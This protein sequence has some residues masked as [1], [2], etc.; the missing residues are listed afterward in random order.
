MLEALRKSTSG[1]IAKVFIG[2]LV[3]SFAV[4]GIED[5]FRTYRQ[6]EVAK[7]GDMVVSAQQFERAYRRQIENVSSRFGRARLT[8]E[9]ARL[10][11]IDR[12][13]LT[14]LLGNATLDNHS[15][16]LNLRLGRETLVEDV[17]S[18]QAFKGLTG[19]FEPA[20]FNAFLRRNGLSEKSF[21]ELREREILRTHLTSALL[22]GVTAPKA[23]IDILYRY[24]QER[25]KAQYF[26]IDPKVLPKLAKPTEAQLKKLYESQKGQFVR[27]DYRKVRLLVAT[28]KILAGRT[29]VSDEAVKRAFEQAKSRYDSPERRRI[30]QIAYD[31]EKDAAAARKKIAGGQSFLDAAK[32]RGAT[33][34]DID[35]GLLTKNALDDKAI[36]D[37]A[38]KLKKG[39]V[40]QPVKGKYK[41]MLLRVGE[42]QPAKKSKFEDVKEEIRTQI[43]RDQARRVAR[44]VHDKVEDLKLSGKSF[45]EVA[46]ALKIKFV[47]I[48]A[49]DS[50]GKAPDGKPAITNPDAAVLVS[51]I[52]ASQ[53]GL[54]NPSEQAS[55]GGY[56]WYEVVSITPKAQKAFKEVREEVAKLWHRQETLKAVTKLAAKLIKR[57]DAGGEFKELAKEAGGTVKESSAVRRNDRGGGLTV[58]AI[59]RLFALKKGKAASVISDDGKTRVVFRLE[60]I[61]AAKDPTP[62]AL[63]QLKNR[64]DQDMRTD[65]VAA[66]VAA[67]Q[68]RYTVNV[69]QPV[70]NRLTGRAAPTQPTR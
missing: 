40:S 39:E 46:D 18:T 64:M 21:A 37:A 20:R 48:P 19:Q 68:K 49:V 45:K 36:A 13:T 63:G 33:K 56:Y 16:A 2:L 28:T 43:Q 57:A 66:Y 11:G 15:N 25:R 17:R 42:I 62:I 34:N 32:A 3:L 58:N 6:G 52:F 23:V 14:T 51:R 24:D 8:Q 31:S 61:I 35:L 67:L 22:Y 10:L 50:E 1:W 54:E 9:Q 60:E 41:T 38:F 44:K 12:R 5:V 29:K 65:A 26:T 30:E 70:F 47:E 59:R 69:N 53:V 4:W 7:V 27:P 55:D